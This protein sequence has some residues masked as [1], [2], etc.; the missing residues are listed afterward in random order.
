MFFWV[1]AIGR[2]STSHFNTVYSVSSFTWEDVRRIVSKNM[3]SDAWIANYMQKDGL[4]EDTNLPDDF[5]EL[6]YYF[7]DTAVVKTANPIMEKWERMYRNEGWPGYVTVPTA[8]MFFEVHMNVKRDMKV[9][10]DERKLRQRYSAFV[11]FV[12][13]HVTGIHTGN[14]DDT[15]DADK[16][17]CKCGCPLGISHICP[18]D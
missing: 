15:A 1:E 9:E 13:K 3:D 12:N 8:Q 4:I 7:P 5:E 10:P 16:G 18:L 11:K 6:R 2:A 14:F 17:R